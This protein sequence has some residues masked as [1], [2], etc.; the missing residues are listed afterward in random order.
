MAA[1]S[2]ATKCSLGRT[3]KTNPN[4]PLRLPPSRCR[5]LSNP[6]TSRRSLVAAAGATVTA[7]VNFFPAGRSGCALQC[8]EVSQ[9]SSL[10]KQN[11][12]PKMK[13]TPPCK[14]VLPWLKANLGKGCLAPLTTVD[15]LA[16]AAAVEIVQL[17]AVTQ[18]PEI[19]KAFGLIVR[20]MQKSTQELA[21]HAIAHC[22]DWHNRPRFWAAAGLEPIPVRMC[23]YEPDCPI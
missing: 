19:V 13:I 17:Y 15:R 2:L 23:K 10:T 3:T 12:N 11:P 16:L 20:Q 9:P 8:A 6:K 7:G 1:A 5:F 21:Y 14:T 22:L 18:H 4:R